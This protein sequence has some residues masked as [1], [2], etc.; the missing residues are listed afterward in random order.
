[1]ALLSR[2]VLLG[3]LLSPFVSALPANSTTSPYVHPANGDCV[4]YTIVTK[5]T[6]ENLKWI[7]PKVENNFDV[8]KIAMGMARS[9]SA[10]KFNPTS[11]PTNETKEYTISATYCS[12]K[13][14]QKGR[15]STVM[16]MTH[17]GGY[18]SRYWNPSYQPEKYSFSWYALEQGYSIF[19]YDRLGVGRSQIVSGYEVQ[20]S[21]QIE[22]LAS[23][24]KNL[25]AGKTSNTKPVSRIIGVGHSLGSFVT[26][27]AIAKYP[28]LVEG[29]PPT[30]VGAWLLTI[31][32]SRIAKTVDPSFPQDSGYLAFSD[33]IP[34]TT[35]FFYS[36]PLDPSSPPLN[37]P[38]IEYAQGIT[39]PIGL[40][41]SFSFRNLSLAAGEFK[42]PV[43]ILSG[44]EDLLNCDGDCEKV[45]AEGG[46]DQVWAGTKPETYVLP[47]AGHGTVFA[48]TA[49]EMFGE[50]VGFVQRHFE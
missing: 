26:N 47:N 40:L 10:E 16:V 21:M 27:A 2:V 5:L 20:A 32:G 23:M 19:V 15:E 30:V 11:G 9:D 8:A 35:T 25:R 31:F 17:G 1:M 3:A 38:T 42:G 41:E 33:I 48:E 44:A 14:E 6:T 46:Q 4:D 39:Q 13:K 45:Y 36:D 24:I 18:D 50:M 22:L 29:T 7:L 28:D 49:Q 37:I 12:P 43:F 34:H